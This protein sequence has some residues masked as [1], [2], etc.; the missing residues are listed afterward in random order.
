MF[1][2]AFL[3][4]FQYNKSGDDIMNNELKTAACYI[5]VSTDK[6]EELSPASQLKEI[7]KWAKVN[8]Y[9]L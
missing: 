1:F 7:R 9:I 4:A 3:Q 6:Q 2:Q 5:R 8:G